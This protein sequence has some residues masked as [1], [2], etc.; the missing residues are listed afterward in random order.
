M[1]K[2]QLHCDCRLPEDGEEQMAY[3]EDGGF[4]GLSSRFQMPFFTLV[5]NRAGACRTDLA[6]LYDTASFIH[7]TK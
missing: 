3:R 4:T 6:N 1:K 7:V 5:T 2:N